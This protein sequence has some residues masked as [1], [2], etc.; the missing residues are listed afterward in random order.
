MRNSV[1]A[2]MVLLPV[3]G[4]CATVESRLP[5]TAE[6]EMPVGANDGVSYFLPRQ[7]A[8]VTAKRTESRLSK[9]VGAVTKAQTAV[10]EAEAAVAAAE[11]EVTRSRSAL[12]ASPDNDT[13]RNLLNVQLSDAQADARTARK[14]LEAKQVA[15]KTATD[16]LTTAAGASRSAGPG[17]YDVALSITLQEPT[18]D[19]R[20]HFRLNPQHSI[21]R[22]DEAKFKISKSGLL[23]SSTIMATDRTGEI[24]LDIA[25]F[26]GAIKGPLFDPL[27]PRDGE[28]QI[29]ECTAE[30]PD[31]L[32]TVV[33]FAD[34]DQVL[35]L[36]N[37]LQCLGVRLSVEQ[38]LSAAS[39]RAPSSNTAGVIN[40]ILYR[41]P[42]EVQIRIEK[43]VLK[44]G[45]CDATTGWYTTQ[46]L[47]L[48]LPQ[49]GPINVLPHQAGLFTKT[50]YS[51]SFD[52]GILTDYDSS[53]PSEL[54]YAAGLPMRIIQ[55]AADAGSKILSIRT[56]QTNN[57]ATL[58][59][60]QLAYA[61]ALSGQQ[62]GGVTNQ[63][64]L[65]EAQLQ[66]ITAQF[67]QQA[68]SINGERTLSEANLA[69]LRAYFAQ[70]AAA[71]EGQR[72][73][74]LSDLA[75]LQA[76]GQLRSAA[77]TGQT[78]LTIEQLALLAATNNLTI[79]QGNT[80]PQLSTAELNALFARMS[81]ENRR[82]LLNQCVAQI[83]ASTPVGTTP[84]IRTCLQ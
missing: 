1:I 11:A 15:L 37:D 45:A 52:A 78:Q 69:L 28:Q 49:A 65:A 63:R 44:T 25:A 19:P 77:V 12:I 16:G 26:A 4:A 3:L 48:M 47:A 72:T 10:A 61:N 5:T 55:S 30:A 2:A 60:A 7:L 35:T 14:T 23:A 21:F 22:D 76:Q 51:H 43:C 33:D 68:G 18:G 84:D 46:I 8:T 81:I 80:A 36:N 20:Q 17:A 34:A 79:A 41:T 54:A 6:G 13:S 74:T 71:A 39:K 42:S 73:L 56:G 83:I 27:A 62:V 58:S 66:L 24:I 29:K 40:G 53:R 38:L 67:A 82:A 32:V 57:L 70:Q 64:Q 9:A 31:E 59:A 50:K 75:L